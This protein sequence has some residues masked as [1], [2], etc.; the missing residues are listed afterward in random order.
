MLFQRVNRSDPE[1]IYVVAKN[2]SGATMT[3]GYPAFWDVE[4]T[5][6]D[7][8]QVTNSGTS[9]TLQAFAGVV[10]ADIANGA[11]GL[12]QI[13]GFRSSA[14]ILSSAGSSAKGDNIT[15]V[16]GNGLGPVAGTGVKQFGFLCSAITASSS[17]QFYTTADIF[18]RAL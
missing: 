17:S 18:I 15:A 3:A 6:A 14:R 10:D 5:T 1:K 12:V 11:Y 13:Y 9:T 2:G 8:V 16:A 4:M 7:G